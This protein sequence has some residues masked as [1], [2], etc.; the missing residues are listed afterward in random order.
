MTSPLDFESRFD[1][2]RDDA[3]SLYSL[4]F[5]ALESAAPADLLRA[6]VRLREIDP[7]KER[8]VCLFAIVALKN[9]DAAGAAAALEDHVKANGESAAVLVNLAKARRAL[10][11]NDQGMARRLDRA[12][13]L[14]PNFENGL[15]LWLL[16]KKQRE[17]Q[18]AHDEA[19]ARLVSLPQ[20]WRA[21]LVLARARLGRQ[22]LAAALRLCEEALAIRKDAS[23][24]SEALTIA[25][26]MLGEA[27]YCN[28]AL[29]IA[30]PLY[31]PRRHGPN[32]AVNLLQCC[33]QAG[34]E[35]VRK[36]LVTQL[37][38]LGDPAFGGVLAHF[39]KL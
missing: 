8:A 21:R 26:A 15:S 25:T 32:P 31:D 19:L 29:K 10:G 11:E 22:D 3:A 2:F 1:A 34:H 36:K 9:K 6:A 23:A 17:G 28:A 20:T 12:V 37:A 16:L 5:S 35:D 39:S 27:G 38:A 13:E 33:V 30:L 4:V 18:T 14:D 7:D 24:E